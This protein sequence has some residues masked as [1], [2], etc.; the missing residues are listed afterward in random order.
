M[1]HRSIAPGELLAK[2]GEVFGIHAFRPGQ[3]ELLQAVLGGRDALGILLIG[4]GN[5]TSATSA[6]G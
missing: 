6:G 3:L 4:G 5:E 2:A 1:E